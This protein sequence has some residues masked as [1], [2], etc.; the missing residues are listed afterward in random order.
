MGLD[1]GSGQ[2]NRYKI[3]PPP[4][5]RLQHVSTQQ[6]RGIGSPIWSGR[7][8]V[9]AIAVVAASIPACL[10][11]TAQAVFVRLLKMKP[12]DIATTQPSH[13]RYDQTAD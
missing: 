5:Y 2:V 13:D 10:D 12:M 9:P 11:V 8:R 4:Q 6:M 3:D 1:A 7:M